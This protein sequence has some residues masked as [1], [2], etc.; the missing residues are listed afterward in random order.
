MSKEKV[1]MQ[2]RVEKDLRSAFLACAQG[3]D[4]PGSQLLRDFMRDYVKKN[5]QREL[6]L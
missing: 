2:I 3:N 4:R 5:R 6:K 1:T